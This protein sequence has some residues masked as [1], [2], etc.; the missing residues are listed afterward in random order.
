[1]QCTGTL[2]L[3]GSNLATRLD[4]IEARLPPYYGWPLP[5][6]NPTTTPLFQIKNKATNKCAHPKGEVAGSGTDIVQTD[7]TSSDFQK[8]FWHSGYMLVN[9]G[10]HGSPHNLWMAWEIADVNVNAMIKTYTAMN[11]EMKQR[12]SICPAAR[13]HDLHMFAIYCSYR[14]WTVLSTVTCHQD[15]FCSISTLSV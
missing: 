3:A 14:A 4:L 9:K 1:M 11:A 13:S 12:W 7:C 15:A 10:A 8:W 2:T 6:T 5:S